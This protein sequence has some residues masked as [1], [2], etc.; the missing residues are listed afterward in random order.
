M[1]KQTRP[2]LSDV[3]QILTDGWQKKHDDRIAKDA[4]AKFVWFESGGKSSR[5]YF[6]ELLHLMNQG[7]CSFCDVYPLED[8]S[9]EPIEHFKPKSKYPE[10]AFTWSNLYYICDLCNNKKRIDYDAKLLRPDDVAYEF[11]T[12]FSFDVSGYIEPNSLASEND[13][14][15]AE[16]TIST[17]GL[18]LKNRPRYRLEEFNKK[19]QPAEGIDFYAY[20]DFLEFKMKYPN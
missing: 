4:K 12:Y 14:R 3:L 20:R 1:R 9:T 6:V 15:R 8:R 5:D 16:F 18:N 17:Y 10:V 13:Q 2:Q 7:H 11:L 19:F